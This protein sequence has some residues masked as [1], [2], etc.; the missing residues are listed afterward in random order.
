MFLGFEIWSDED[1]GFDDGVYFD[2]R[3]YNVMLRISEP[4]E[5]GS[6][7]NGG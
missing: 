6:W 1:G 2:E 7:L 4:K 3:F 5:F